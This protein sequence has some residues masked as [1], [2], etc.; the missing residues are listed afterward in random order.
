MSKT[1]DP[2]KKDMPALSSK[3]K[4]T[5]AL[6]A[7]VASAGNELNQI[8]NIQSYKGPSTEP[9]EE[10]LRSLWDKVYLTIISQIFDKGLSFYN[11][12]PKN[13]AMDLELAVI[14]AD[15]AV[16]AYIRTRNIT[17]DPVSV[18]QARWAREQLAKK[19][20]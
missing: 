4:E 6:L 19:T 5:A 12:K 8:Q 9:N 1:N 15:E 17:P 7:T 16:E 20:Y 18:A 11:N 3:D 13:L 2:F 10:L 14:R